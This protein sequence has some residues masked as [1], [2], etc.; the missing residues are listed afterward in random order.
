MVKAA[1][2]GK[3]MNLLK[4]HQECPFCG[5]AFWVIRL[6]VV[7]VRAATTVARVASSATRLIMPLIKPIVRMG[8]EA[9]RVATKAWKYKDL[10]GEAALKAAKKAIKKCLKKMLKKNLKDMEL[11]DCTLK[12]KTCI[13]MLNIEVEFGGCEEMDDSYND[14]SVQY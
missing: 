8:K 2:D 9:N 12:A 4:S 6:A 11:E 5:F 10:I 1:R 7:A 14:G 13:T 3:L